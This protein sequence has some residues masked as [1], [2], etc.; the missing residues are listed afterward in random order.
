MPS[1]P[2]KRPDPSLARIG[3]LLD[4]ALDLSRGSIEYWF[5]Q[6]AAHPSSVW[7]LE[8]L[9]RSIR[10]F[11]SIDSWLAQDPKALD[12]LTE[13]RALLSEPYF[14]PRDE[15]GRRANRERARLVQSFVA[16]SD[17]AVETSVI[18]GKWWATERWHAEA[19]KWIDANAGARIVAIEQKTLEGIRTLIHECFAE[20]GMGRDGLRQSILALDGT[21]GKVRFGLDPQRAK[22]FNKF[23]N[24]LP[25]GSGA[26]W[27]KRIKGLADRE[28]KRLLKA[29]AKTIA[30]TEVVNAGN[31]AMAET[32][33]LAVVE[34]QISD[35]MYL[36]EWV[37]RATACKRCD[38][39]DGATRELTSGRFYSDGTWKGVE[40]IELPE[41][42]IF[43]FC[44]LRSVLRSLALRQPGP[45]GENLSIRNI[46]SLEVLLAA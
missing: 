17:V 27:E 41:V 33:R 21:G 45:P 46:D 10:Q 26:R 20:P 11:G 3:Q 12:A 28:Y 36:L 15:R 42:H 44:F 22:Q 7:N 37:T 13:F 23:L 8:D 9:V 25:E 31:Q 43:G 30:Q 40:S 1:P 34:G 14:G 35:K 24:Q 19:L 5:E 6:A 29:R 4:E 32:Y 38:A 2:T 39:F 18:P 16:A